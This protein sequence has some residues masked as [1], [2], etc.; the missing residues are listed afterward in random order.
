METAC[1]ESLV[2]LVESSSSTSLKSEKEGHEDLDCQRDRGDDKQNRLPRHLGRERSHSSDGVETTFRRSDGL[3]RTRSGDGMSRLTR[4]RSGD[5]SMMNDASFRARQ[6]VGNVE[7]T[8]RARQLVA[9]KG[10]QS[11]SSRNLLAEDTPDRDKEAPPKPSR[12]TLLD[13]DAKSWES[14]RGSQASSRALMLLQSKGAESLRDLHA[15]FQMERS[16]S[17]FVSDDESS[18][19]VFSDDDSVIREDSDDD[20]DSIEPVIEE[21]E[22]EESE[23]QERDS[24]NPEAFSTIILAP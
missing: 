22:E 13:S 10:Y 16:Q 8:S 5:G 15:S 7:A 14:Y 2:P 20:E 3:S 19:D 9:A 12:P 23:V 4:S 1:L 11:F 24:A 6:L 17:T 18:D 21:V